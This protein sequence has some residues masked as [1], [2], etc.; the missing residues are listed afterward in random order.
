[1][2]F[3]SSS[4]KT[5][6]VQDA[7]IYFCITLDVKNATIYVFMTILALRWSHLDF[8]SFCCKGAYLPICNGKHHIL[9]K[10]I[11]EERRDVGATMLESFEVIA[12]H[13][14]KQH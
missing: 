4:F 7:A 11:Y 8:F 12:S 5:F 14:L 2:S 1:L 3:P 13:T 6:E 9:E 10:N